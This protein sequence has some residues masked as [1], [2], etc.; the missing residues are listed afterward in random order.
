MIQRMISNKYVFEALDNKEITA[1]QATDAML[2]SD[3]FMSSWRVKLASLC[4]R[5]WYKGV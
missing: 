3:Y 5:W 2:A 1:D 4:N